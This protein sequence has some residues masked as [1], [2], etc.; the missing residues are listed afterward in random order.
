[1]ASYSIQA[2]STSQA[3]PKL[4]RGKVLIVTQTSVYFKVGNDPVA[5]RTGCALI[6]AGSTRELRLP[7]GCLQIAFIA[8][9]DPGNV[10]IVEVNETKA[11]CSA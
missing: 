7:T 1:M 4:I 10:S 9:K 8:V 6:P 11:S 2:N 3:T 5:D